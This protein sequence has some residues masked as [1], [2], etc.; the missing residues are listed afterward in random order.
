ML[1]QC[2]NLMVHFVQ[3]RERDQSYFF[4]GQTSIPYS[5]VLHLKQLKLDVQFSKCL[6]FLH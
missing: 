2:S 5:I 1:G 6:L 3:Y 4:V